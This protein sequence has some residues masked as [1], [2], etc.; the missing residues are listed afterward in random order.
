MAKIKDLDKYLSNKTGLD[1]AER[2]Q[3]RDKIAELSAAGNKHEAW[4]VF[5]SF[6]YWKVTYQTPQ[7]C[8]STNF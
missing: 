2:Q 1:K 5:Q 7:K 4:K 8:Q 6:Q 3:W